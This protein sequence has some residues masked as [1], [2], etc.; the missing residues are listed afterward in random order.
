MFTGFI[1]DE[2]GQAT[3]DMEWDIVGESIQDFALSP[4]D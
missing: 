1:W 3:Q 4:T 2:S